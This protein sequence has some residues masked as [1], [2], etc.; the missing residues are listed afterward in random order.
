MLHH[1]H[2]HRGE[3]IIEESV[4]GRKSDR[5]ARGQGSDD[6]P[7]SGRGQSACQLQRM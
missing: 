2:W 4:F 7:G 6:D 5:I 1:L 3:H